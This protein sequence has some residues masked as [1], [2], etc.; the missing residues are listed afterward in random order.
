MV[1]D[2]AIVDFLIGYHDIKN[3]MQTENYMQTESRMEIENHMVL[4]VLPVIVSLD[5]RKIIRSVNIVSFNFFFVSLC[6]FMMKCRF[7]SNQG[8]E[9][10]VS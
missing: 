10:M 4:L 9:V 8:N 1:E 3:L 7:L 2:S 5:T 6:V